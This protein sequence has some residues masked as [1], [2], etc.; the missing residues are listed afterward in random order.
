MAMPTV[1]GKKDRYAAMAA[2]GAMPV[3]SNWLRITT[4]MGASATT[5]I[6]CD[7]TIQGIRPRSMLR[8]WRARTLKPTPRS[9][10]TTKPSS[11]ASRV[12]PA[13]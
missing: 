12:S 1:T 4:I 5:G 11:V 6:V 13:W 9:D 8:L 3:T 7:A 10:P 2:F